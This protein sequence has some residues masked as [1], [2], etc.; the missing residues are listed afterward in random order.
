MQF[1]QELGGS[2]SMQTHTYRDFDAFTHDVRDVDCVMMLQNP[3]RRLW[4]VSH[5]N[6][7]GV[8]VQLG[9]L[10]SGNIVE[11]QSWPHG[12]LIYLP[13]TDGCAYTAN[14][15]VF[16]RDSF[17]ILEPGS[18][19]HLSTR[20]AH[21][22]CT[23]FVPTVLLARGG[24]HIEPSSGSERMTCRVTRPNR[25]IAK[26]F[27]AFVDQ[28]MSAA[29]NCPQLG[30]TQAARFAAAE[31]VSIVSSIVGEPQTGKPDQE[32]RPRIPRQD[33]IDRCGELLEE[34]GGERVPVGD[35]AAA[36]EVSERTLR[37]AFNEYYGVG[38][39]RYLQTR[40]LHR[41]YRE[42][43][44][45]DPASKSVS[46]VLVDQGVWE[47]GRF[48]SRYRLLFGELPSETLR[49]AR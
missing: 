6:L 33:I 38:P 49:R 29:G 22:W 48:A 11:G 31:A 19:F 5:V 26:Q 1:R 21:D 30:A 28:I 46:D 45:R 14:G 41:V 13:L 15:A 40:Q 9:R 23:I 10:G 2:N 37:T 43:R 18:E 47:F 34:R 4:S 39:V 20:D 25:Q 32:G 24:D 35:L 3:K 16:G 12:Y 42:L 27:E 8:H 36:A 7:P 44:A 17:M